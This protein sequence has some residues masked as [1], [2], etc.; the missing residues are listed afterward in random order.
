M[1]KIFY[2]ILSKTAEVYIDDILVKS[3]RQEYH[4]ANLQQAFDLS[5]HFGMKLNPTKC[6]FSVSTGKFLGFVVTKCGIE[7]DYTQIKAVQEL[8]SSH[9]Y[10]EKQ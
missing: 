7:I 3:K 6:P 4:Y 1:T 2:P 5:R 9:K 10:F 8:P